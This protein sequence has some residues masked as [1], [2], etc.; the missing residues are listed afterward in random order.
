MISKMQEVDNQSL[1][2]SL[3][4]GSQEALTEVWNRYYTRFHMHANS[5]LKDP[6]EAEDVVQE[7][8]MKLCKRQK[9]LPLNVNMDAYLY[10]MVDYACIDHFRRKKKKPVEYREEDKLP[11]KAIEHDPLVS[12]EEVRTINDEIA[13]LHPA[14]RKVLELRIGDLSYKEIAEKTG[15]SINTI[16]NQLVRAKET[17]RKKLLFPKG[18]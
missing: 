17:L 3:I 7:V 2:T 16:G 15:T 9:A 13:N 10:K 1:W 6:H 5:L 12:K 14:E 11:V 18:D 4:D 8:F